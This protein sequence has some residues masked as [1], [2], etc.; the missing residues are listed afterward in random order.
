MDTDRGGLPILTFPDLAAWEDWLG[1][2]PRS[3][4]GVWL[5][6]AKAGND[7]SSLTKAQAID[8]ALCHGWIDRKSVV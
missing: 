6:L 8:G 3:A 4:S 5:K 7:A 2:Q 1:T